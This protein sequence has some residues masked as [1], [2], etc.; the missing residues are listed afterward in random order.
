LNVNQIKL[1]GLALSTSSYVN[2]NNLIIKTALARGISV[3]TVNNCTFNNM[4]IVTSTNYNSIATSKDFIVSNS[5]FN[6][7]LS[8]GL[9]VDACSRFKIL[10]CTFSNNVDGA[11]LTNN[12]C[13][14]YTIDD[15]MFTKTNGIGLYVATVDNHFSVSNSLFT[16][17]VGD[18]IDT[19]T[20]GANNYTI[21]GCQFYGNNKAID[22]KSTDNWFIISNC[23]ADSGDAIDI[24]AVRTAYRRVNDT[25]CTLTES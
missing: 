2:I 4:N 25:I 15:C 12:V 9:D 19:V 7:D 3:T 20:S 21:N 17:N 22:I 14:Y 1:N 11:I 24:N 13:S 8:Y 18:G 23:I 5:Y 10:G 16:N 6:N